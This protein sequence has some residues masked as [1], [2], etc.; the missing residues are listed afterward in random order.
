M[1]SSSVNVCDNGPCLNCLEQWL[2]AMGRQQQA[3][4]AISPLCVHCCCKL[5]GRSQVLC[6]R[7]RAQ[8]CAQLTHLWSERF[9]EMLLS[10][11]G[12][13]R[14]WSLADF[15]TCKHGTGIS[16][17]VVYTLHVASTFNLSGSWTCKPAKVWLRMQSRRKWCGVYCALPWFSAWVF[18][19]PARLWRLHQKQMELIARF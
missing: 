5:C 15:A 12:T 4:I 10:W 11:Y 18:V 9:L 2:L 3:L 13:S 8:T 14:P 7:A 16:A 17:P 19:A 6:L 1:V